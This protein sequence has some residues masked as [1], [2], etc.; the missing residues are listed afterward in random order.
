MKLEELLKNGYINNKV[1]REL[2]LYDKYFEIE[3]EDFE[4]MDLYNCYVCWT[5]DVFIIMLKNHKDFYYVVD[6]DKFIKVKVY[7]KYAI[8][9]TDD[10]IILLEI[11]EDSIMEVDGGEWV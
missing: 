4:V 10:N 9:E 7:Q 6:C 1:I 11:A 2:S 3:E 8:I 5:F